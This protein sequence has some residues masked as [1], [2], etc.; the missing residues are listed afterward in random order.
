MTVINPNVGVQENNLSRIQQEI[1]STVNTCLPAEVTSVEN[2]NSDQTIQVRPL[3]NEIYPDQTALQHSEIFG[4]PVM[5]PSAGGGLLSFPIEVG[6]TVL[7]VF[8]QRSIAEWLE[9]EGGPATPNNY[10]KLSLTDAIAI[11]GLYTK[12]SNLSPN[13]TDVELKFANTSVRIAPSGNL[14]AAVSGDL[15]ATSTGNAMIS[16]TGNVNLVSNQNVTI[17][18]VGNVDINSASLR[19]NGTNIGDTHRHGGV[20]TGGSNT[21]T[22]V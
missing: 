5:F 20:Q 11:P 2:L 17:T 13:T 1:R 3:I 10:R 9:D 18:A 4:V 7:V 14:T 8:A 19:H 12:M 16:A 15:L 21:S 22:P 6:D